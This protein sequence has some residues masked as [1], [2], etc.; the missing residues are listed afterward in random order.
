[1]KDQNVEKTPRLSPEQTTTLTFYVFEKTK[2]SKQTSIVST[3]D[4]AQI[5]ALLQDL[6]KELENHP[7]N[8]QMKPII[9]HLITLLTENHA[10]PAGISPQDLNILLEPPKAF[11]NRFDNGIL[12][13]QTTSSQWFC[14]FATTGT[15]SA[16]PIIILPRLIPIILTPIPRIFV[17][18]STQDGLTSVGGL[19]SGKGFIAYGNQKGFALGFWGIGF[20]VFLPPISQYGIIG[21]ALYAKVS[22]DYMEFWPLNNPPEITETDPVNDQTMVPVTLNELR[23]SIADKDKDLMSYT[24]T[25]NPDVGSGSGGLKPDGVYSIPISGL[26]SLTTYTWQIS[27]NDGKDTTEQTLTFT[28]TP[29]APVVSNPIPGVNERDVSP[30]LSRL[31]FQLKDYQGDALE[32]TVQ[33]QPNIGSDH[34][35][36]VYNGTYSVTVSGVAPGTAYRWFVNATDGNEWTRKVYRFMTGYPSPFDPF[37]YGWH[38]RKQIIINHTQVADDLQDFTVLLST[39]DPDLMKAQASGNDLLFMNDVGSAVKLHHEIESFDG[40][41]GALVAWVNIP[42][43]SSTQD[44][45][46]Y[47]Y[48]GNPD[49]VDQ[50]YPQKTWNSH[51]QG[52]WHL[53]N[54]PTGKILDSTINDNYGTN[55]GGMIQSDLV[56]GKIGKCLNFDGSD[57]FISLSSSLKGQSGT[58]EAWIYLNTPSDYQCIVTKGQSDSNSA[59]FMF[60]CP[61]DAAGFYSRAVGS[62]AANVVGGDTKILSA[63]HHVVG[64]SDGNIWSVYVDGHLESL[65]VIGGS[66]NGEWFDDFTG[67]TYTIGGLN[68]PSYWGPFDGYIDE[69]RVSNALENQ[70][71]VTA[72][73]RNQNDP[74]SFSTFGP[75]VPGS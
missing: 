26:E 15:G 52:V 38:Y 14:N 57:D 18:W 20:S 64:I 13:F 22:A 62:G 41:T 43:L 17:K 45:I 30:D 46:F 21:Y 36:G 31:Q 6:K 49:A 23:F 1:M 19:R 24:V 67:D 25:T 34:K 7:Y 66:N 27:V 42:L 29:T 75:E 71:W 16:F 70:D 12:P 74:S 39:T 69:V 68:R 54:D 72:L 2:V 47:V 37:A 61:G 44:T 5:N 3:Q 32:Y 8:E 9:Q 28:T 51:Y 63:W 60:C 56:D 73:F 53:N 11:T 4:A 40:S 33:T 50:S 10:L 35:T 59:Y 65:T 58:I 55:H 48:Y